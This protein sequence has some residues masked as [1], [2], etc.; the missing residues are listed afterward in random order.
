MDWQDNTWENPFW[1]SHKPVDIQFADGQIKRLTCPRC[2]GRQIHS[3]VVR[4]RQSTDE[5]GLTAPSE[6]VPLPTVEPV[7]D[8]TPAVAFHK[9]RH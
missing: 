1:R 5:Q 4:W 8:L 7:K 2:S 9:S 6:G 3:L